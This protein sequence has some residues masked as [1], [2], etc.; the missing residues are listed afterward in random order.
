ME[1]KKTHGT[2]AV[3][4]ILFNHESPRRRLEFVTRKISHAVA[5]IKRGTQN[6][7]R[8]GD[9]DATRDWG[10]AG[11]YVRA[12]W[13]SLQQPEPRDYVITTGEPRTVLEFVEEAFAV[14][15]LDWRKYVTLDDQFVRQDKG[16]RPCGDA[17]LAR[18]ELGWIPETGFRDLVRMMV[19]AALESP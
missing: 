7:L 19:L 3:S 1:K 10:F 6:E 14:I 5:A 8:L 4:G 11:D 13:L 16:Y 15:D 17:S 12:M 9:L 2:Y 18:A